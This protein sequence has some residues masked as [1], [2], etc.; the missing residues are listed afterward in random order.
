MPDTPVSFGQRRGSPVR[1]IALAVAPWYERYV[2]STFC[3][4]VCRR[5]MRIAFSLASAPPFVKNT[6]LRSP[7]ARPAMSRAASLRASL[8]NA[9]WIMQSLSACSLIAAT[10]FGCW[11]PMLVLTNCDAKSR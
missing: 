2:E 10:T 7:G 5:A 8:A 6:R 1:A 11:W 3:R 9:G 4:P